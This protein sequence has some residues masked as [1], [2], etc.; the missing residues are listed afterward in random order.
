[1]KQYS[2]PNNFKSIDLFQ[3][4]KYNE[5]FRHKKQLR[6]FKK[7][8]GALKTRKKNNDIPLFEAAIL[9]AEGNAITYVTQN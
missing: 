3:Q 5:T 2:S 6:P 1:M 7:I 9:D 8:V 4:Q